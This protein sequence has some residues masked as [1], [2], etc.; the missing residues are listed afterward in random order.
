MKRP[1]CLKVLRWALFCLWALGVGARAQ[2]PISN[3]VV[4]VG[5]TIRDSGGTNWSYV[6]IGAPQYQLLAGK[7]FAIYGKAGYPTNAGAFT[8]R[9]TIFQQSDA[10]AI[11]T[12]LNES[13]ALGENLTVLSHAFDT[14]LHSNPTITNV[15]LPQKVLLGFQTAA[16]NADTAQTIGLLAHLHAG[17]ILCAGQGFAEAI[18]NVTTYEVR[19]FNLATGQAAQ[20][21]GRVTV[22]PGSPTVLPAPGLPFQVTTHDATDNLRIRLRWGTSDAFRRLSL[23]SFGFNVWRIPLAVAV[24][25][26]YTNN[27]PTPAQLKLDPNFTNVNF[28]PV[29]ATKDFSIYSGSG[30][31]D[32]PA[33]QTTYFFSDK[34]GYTGITTSTTNSHGIVLQL[35]PPPFNDG[36]QFYYFITARDVLGRDGLVSPGGWAE[37]CRRTPPQP[38]AKVQ[39][40]NVFQVL[41]SGST[42]TNAQ[43]LMLNWQQNLNTNDQV[44]EYWVYRWPNP[45]MALTNDAAPTNNRI[46]VVLQL[47][48][49]STNSY[50]DNGADA[51]LVP[52]PANYWYTVRAVSQSA[53]GPLLSPHSMPVWGVLRERIG[54]AAANGQILGS[55]GS[56]VVMFE[57]FVTITNSGPPDTKN[58]NYLFACQR[59]DPGTAWVEFFITNQSGQAQTLGPIYFPPG[60]DSL[61][62]AYSPSIS[63][64]NDVAAVACVAGTAYGLMSAPATVSLTSA[65]ASN[66]QLETVFLAGQVM[67]T[68]L[69]STNSLLAALGGPAPCFPA[70]GAKAYPDGTV[71]MQ[72]DYAGPSP[73]LIQAG[74]GTW[75]DVSIATRDPNGYYSVYYPACLLGPLPNFQG[76]ELNLPSEGD[77]SQHVTRGAGNGPVNPVQITFTLTKRTH[78]F[79]LYRTIDN[80]PLTMIAQGKATF[81]PSDPYATIVRSD[82]AMPPSAALL[83]YY[84][85]LLD[86]HGNGSP[87]SF[88]GCKEV[89]PAQL[90]RPVLAEPQAVGDSGNP[91]V[92]LNW[93]CP[94]SGV[95]RF[96]VLVQRADYPGGGVPLGFSSGNFTALSTYNTLASFLGLLA[97]PLDVAQFDAVGLTPP[98]GTNFG[99][100][101][102]F[103]LT[104]NLLANV[105][106]NISVAAV[107]DQG[108]AGELSKVRT[109]IWQQTNGLPSVPWPARPL[110]KVNAFD[111]TNPAPPAI[112]PRVAAVLLS[113]INSVLD[114]NYPVG[115]R[116]GNLTP[117]GYPT[118]NIG[119]TNF[120]TYPIAKP[121]PVLYS[122]L[123]P[124]IDPNTMIFRRLSQNHKRH[125]ESLLPIVVYRQQ[126]TNLFFPKVSGTLTQVT[127]L[128]ERLA[129]GTVL[130]SNAF[131]NVTI[132]DRLIAG[133]TEGRNGEFLYLRD[134][135][136]VMLGASYQYFVVRFNDQREIAEIIPAGTVT[137]P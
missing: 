132:Y 111:D 133:G 36:D 106:Y 101:P 131:Y 134:Q 64:T 50:Q 77:C 108:N 88:L 116:I 28:A 60:G 26:G 129:Y 84:V 104:A 18:T 124:Q 55:C 96:E 105:P 137:I 33:D 76:C 46:N 5:T 79:R 135:Q 80:G 83:C 65:P 7:Q 58:W 45:A 13:V 90:P 34:N 40:Q 38:P 25:A 78:E 126:V 114:G 112:H 109:F 100:G 44:A 72:F 86:E 35:S 24:A 51:P 75:A 66:V 39:V 103:N 10:N 56:P 57:N 15:P 23:L 121:P 81:D 98:A 61:Q 48:N 123:S 113:D 22:V 2:T 4:T 59:S 16:T 73:L 67:L 115:I 63:T 53:C 125:G 74:N 107:D 12:L 128:L 42:V 49:S 102:K 94:T 14:L 17:L 9:G 68:S 69:K 91:Q 85:Q 20:V 122:T 118:E 19:E 93:F 52:G 87:M 127:P 41:D 3:L 37:A 8:L 47:S 130:V 30:G 1:T 54:P 21:V 31:A 92:M 97:N 82:D 119:T 27:P 6:L 89:K 136:P 43:F 117:V 95:Y 70:L 29:M 11:N 110:A 120:F 62:V 99:P 32:D 71:R